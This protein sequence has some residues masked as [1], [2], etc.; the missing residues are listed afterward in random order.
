MHFHILLNG[1]RPKKVSKLHLLLQPSK[2]FL[3]FEIQMTVWKW[4][5][6]FLK[7]G[8]GLLQAVHLDLNLILISVYVLRRP[9]Q[10]WKKAL[11]DWRIG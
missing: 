5:K 11:I 3:K 4:Q 8:L 9:S 1:Q 10:N 6:I 7:R 2:H